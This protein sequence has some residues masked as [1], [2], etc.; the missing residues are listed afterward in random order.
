MA[1]NVEFILNINVASYQ[2]RLLLDLELCLCLSAGQVI[3][4]TQDVALNLLL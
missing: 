2:L 4:V 3:M 1:T